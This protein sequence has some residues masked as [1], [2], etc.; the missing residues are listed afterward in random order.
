M[1]K[2][3]ENCAD[4]KRMIDTSSKWFDGTIDW[5][6]LRGGGDYEVGMAVN[7]ATKVSVHGD[8]VTVRRT[9]DIV[10]E[11]RGGG[12][13]CTVETVWCENM[14]FYEF[15]VSEWWDMAM[16]AFKDGDCHADSIY[17]KCDGD[18]GCRYL[19]AHIERHYR[20]WL[21]NMR[22]SRGYDECSV[23]LQSNGDMGFSFENETVEGDAEELFGLIAEA[24]AFRAAGIRLEDG[25]LT[26]EVGDGR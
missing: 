17:V 18:D 5:A 10:K 21:G 3:P 25:K 16:D 15:M 19:D 11:I 22:L 6:D 23:W 2:F 26:V 9:R 7:Q 12:C 14:T 13:S 24:K 20:D 1:K 4:L 8:T